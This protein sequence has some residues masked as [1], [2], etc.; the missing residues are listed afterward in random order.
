MRPITP[1]AADGVSRF[2]QDEGAERGQPP[3]FGIK[4]INYPERTGASATGKPRRR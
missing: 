1:F 4:K 3:P 2:R